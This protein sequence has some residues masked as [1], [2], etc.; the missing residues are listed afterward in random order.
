M[1][2]GE[3]ARNVGGGERRPAPPQGGRRNMR[4]PRTLL[5]CVSSGRDQGCGGP[6]RPL[7]LRVRLLAR[8]AWG[9]RLGRPQA[10]LNL[11]GRG[12]QGSAAAAS[13]TGAHPTHLQTLARLLL[14]LQLLPEKV[15]LPSAG[16][17][18]KE[19]CL[20]APIS[21]PDPPCP[22][23]LLHLLP[24][25]LQRRLQC[26]HLLRELHDAVVAFVCGT[27]GGGGMDGGTLLGVWSQ[28]DRMGAIP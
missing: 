12:R 5:S 25:Q 13:P 7:R 15:Q 20:D 17:E 23:H 26:L 6:A 1:C 19:R 9:G 18:T 21:F 27:Q 14:A 10:Q 8:G 3:T 24:H 4:T 28:L 11:V 2:P 16:W 22:S